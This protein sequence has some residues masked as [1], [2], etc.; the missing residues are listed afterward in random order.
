[1]GAVILAISLGV[2]IVLGLIVYVRVWWLRRKLARRGGGKGSDTDSEVFEVE[3][4]VL[5]ERDQREGRD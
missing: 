4:R 1:M 2:A 5:D 3:Y